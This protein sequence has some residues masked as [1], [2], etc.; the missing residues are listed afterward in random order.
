MPLAI[1]INC[2]AKLSTDADFTP[3]I[4]EFD[5]YKRNSDR[6]S[7]PTR[8]EQEEYASISPLFGRDRR[9]VDTE[10]PF[11]QAQETLSHLHNRQDDSVWTDEEGDPLSQWECTSDSYLIYSYFVHNGIRYYYI[12][13]FIDNDAHANW[14]NE[15]AKLMWIQ[16][17]KDYR[18]S[19]QQAAA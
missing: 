3:F 10:E 9:N 6:H 17:A 2:C 8:Q 15:E 14:D 7:A 1:E 5:A 4:Q 12:V 13:D 19:I 18:L 11:L 16:E